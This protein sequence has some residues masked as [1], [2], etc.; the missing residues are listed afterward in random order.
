MSITGFLSRRLKLRVNEAKSAVG[1][2]W[3]RSFLGFSLSWKTNLRVSNKA[4]KAIKQRVRE[5][6][7]RTCGRGIEQIVQE[8][9]KY[10]LGWKAYFGISQV[11]Y[12]FKALDS[13]I[14]RRLR[15]Y[16]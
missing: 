5:I 11:R 3:N 10:L 12:I 7:F 16:L 9:R 4:L 15:C 2:P 8:L 13:W 14:K 1:R 6:T